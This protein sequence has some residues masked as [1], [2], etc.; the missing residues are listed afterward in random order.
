M[1]GWRLGFGEFMDLDWYLRLN[2]LGFMDEVKRILKS[3]LGFEACEI[4]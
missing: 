3:C 1:I 4:F 2:L